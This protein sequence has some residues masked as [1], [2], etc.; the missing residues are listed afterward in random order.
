MNEPGYDV[1]GDVH[2]CGRKL[3]ELLTSLG[4]DDS[5]GHFA[6]PVR[7]AV[8]VGDL[9]DRGPEQLLTLRTV[10]A[11]T[12]AGAA[13]VVMGNHEFNAIAFH[14]PHPTEAG[15]HLRERS[16]KNV[17]QHQRFLEEVTQDSSLHA[18]VIDWF[19]TF[20]LWLQLDGLRVV[21]ACW[22]EKSMA[23]LG[24]N[25]TLTHDVLRQSSIKGT[26]EHEA[27]E[28]LLKGPEIPIDP[29]YYDKDGHLRDMA[30]FA[31]WKADATTVQEATVIPSGVT[32]TQPVTN[33]PTEEWAFAEPDAPVSHRPV[34]PYPT[35][36]D[37]V[38]F[39]HYWR[40]GVPET[41]APS[42]ACVDYSACKR[43]D[44]VA[45]RWSGESELKQSSFST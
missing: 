43:G 23:A 5:S 16:E 10:R 8:F 13:H 26:P 44:L 21:H 17:G 2:G 18:E 25:S 32:A 45:Y 30:R 22:D 39:G 20:P 11:M 31:W 9:I 24:D 36:A 6:H 19:F 12:D 15:R 34:E 38:I 27:I 33:E 37:P 3:V 40:V 41:V 42:A 14:T 7:K 35:E 29:P 28:I 4:Y 1:I